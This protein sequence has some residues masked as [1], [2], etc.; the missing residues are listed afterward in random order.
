MIM[1]F[2]CVDLSEPRRLRYRNRLMFSDEWKLVEL[3]SKLKPSA[4]KL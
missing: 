2:F 4:V 3:D 1:S